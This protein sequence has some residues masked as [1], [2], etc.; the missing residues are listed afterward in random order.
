[1]LLTS[2]QTWARNSKL[3]NQQILEKYAWAD[4]N[5]DGQISKS[6]RSSF[7]KTYRKKLEQIA[8]K[9]NPKIDANKNGKV[10]KKE[11][12]LLNLIVDA[13]MQI[14]EKNDKNAP[15]TLSSSGSSNRPSNYD[16]YPTAKRTSKAPK[17][18]GNSKYKK[19]NKNTGIDA[20]KT[21]LNK[22]EREKIATG[23]TSII[24]KDYRNLDKSTK[25]LGLAFILD[26]GNQYAST[27]ND[28]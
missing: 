10:D 23:L 28:S 11:R 26:P 27:V 9:S 22:M 1:M 14:D 24:S 2:V 16:I 5:K 6:E 17:G 4:K 18:Q 7:E 20:S 25:Y 13:M 8:I 12:K 3:T 19:P 15:V 21:S